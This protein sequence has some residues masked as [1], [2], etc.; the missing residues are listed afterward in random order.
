MLF[1]HKFLSRSS[2]VR[3]LW[4]SADVR[5]V[6]IFQQQLKHAITT[7]QS[8]LEGLGNPLAQL[9]GSRP[10]NTFLAHA[11]A[12]FTGNLQLTTPRGYLAPSIDDAL[13]W[14][15]STYV[16]EMSS[17]APRPVNSQATAPM[18][19]RRRL[20]AAFERRNLI[21]S[22]VVHREYA[23]EGRHAPWT[24]DIAYKDDIWHLV[25]SVALNAPIPETNLSRA[26]I[27]KGM[28]EEVSH[29]RKANGVAVVQL[30]REQTLRAD[31]QEAQSILND[32]DIEL[33][34]INVLDSFIDRVSTELA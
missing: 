28:L 2:T 23:I 3:R 9:L 11:A 22:N 18:R 13:Q 33:V 19:T 31:V 17:G 10:D 30:P 14:A 32:S 27:F 4:P 6:P 29:S 8:A 16:S 25:H 34:D 5:V 1:Q 21:A 26:L 20:W 12:E 24:F 7:R 15:Y